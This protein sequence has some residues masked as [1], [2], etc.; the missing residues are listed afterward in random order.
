MRSIRIR[1]L[2]TGWKTTFQDLGRRRTERT[3]VPRGGAADQ[4]SARLANVLVGNAQGASLVE[5]L[6]GAFHFV[7]NADLLIAATGSVRAIRVGGVPAELGRPLAVPAFA[8]VRVEW[9][10]W[11][12]RSYIAFSG[13]LAAPR[14]L[15]S[16]AP[17]ARMGFAQAIAQDRELTL[18]TALRG[19]PRALLGGGL[20]EAPRPREPRREG[21]RVIDLVDC[22]ETD[23]VPGIRELLAGTQYTVNGRSDHVGVR[24]DGP[25][26]HPEGNAQVTS[27]GVPVGALEIPPSD[28]LILLGRYRTLTAGYPI[29]GFA[30]ETAQDVMGQLLPGH[31]I[32]FRWTDHDAAR[33]AAQAAE[34]EL[35][36][37]ERGAARALEALDWDESPPGLAAPDGDEPQ[38][39]PAR[40][41][42][43]RRPA[44][45]TETRN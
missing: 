28:E 19:I 7:A 26:L 45:Q 10:G 35:A 37:I 32:R 2:E 36:E 44:H 11:G 1:V 16:V 33:A 29:V 9:A 4:G 3:G 38:P 34:E 42:G 15:G 17:D 21:T 31:R 22:E 43:G 5:S 27:H 25:V 39:D 20:L 23:S 30:T 18:R 13:E 41:D 24:L 8:D 6:G 14:F 40:P 12:A